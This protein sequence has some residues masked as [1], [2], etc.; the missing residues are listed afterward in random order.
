MPLKGG[1]LAASASAGTHY[2]STGMS[3]LRSATHELAQVPIFKDLVQDDPSFAKLVASALAPANHEP[4]DTISET[5]ATASEMYFVVQGDV[6]V[7]LPDGRQ[8][9]VLGPVSDD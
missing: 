6:L 7:V 9:A 2:M 1:A 3:N 8:A 4:G 5:G